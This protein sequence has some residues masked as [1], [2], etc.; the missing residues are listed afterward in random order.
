M[1]DPIGT[2]ARSEPEEHLR[3]VLRGLWGNLDEA[4]PDSPPTATTGCA[5]P[6]WMQLAVSG[7]VFIV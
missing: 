1:S 4:V 5:E 3:V 2:Q 6:L 7:Q